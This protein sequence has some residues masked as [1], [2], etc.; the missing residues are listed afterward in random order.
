MRAC[1]GY[2]CLSRSLEREDA[3]EA[4]EAHAAQ[5]PG[6]GLPI[7]APVLAAV[8]A[9]AAALFAGTPLDI[10]RAALDPWRRRPA[11]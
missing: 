1:A 4:R 2:T 10:I 5:A 11:T 6:G 8:S 9:P 3:R 7:A